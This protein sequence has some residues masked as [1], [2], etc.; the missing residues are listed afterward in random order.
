[1][2]MWAKAVE[3][4]VATGLAAGG[5][6]YAGMWPGSQ[7][8]GH[9]LTA[10]GLP[11]ELALTFDDGPNPRWTPNLLEVLARHEV[12][13]TFFLIGQYAAQQKALVREMQSAGH[14]LGNHTWTHPN[15]A[16]T[17]PGRTRE[18]LSRTKREIESITGAPVRLFRPPF[19]A[20]SPWTG[21]IARSLG[22]EV[23][24]WNAMTA[25]WNAT[26]PEPVAAALLKKIGQNRRAGHA[27]NLVLH[28]GSHRTPVAERGASVGAV[29]QILSARI[30]NV[31]LVTVAAWVG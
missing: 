16:R 20:R 4:S 13:A 22:M 23:V 11:G 14:T 17:G 31:R 10:P 15:L 7:I 6:A 21:P 2:E 5:Y 12:K 9:T 19:G 28:D 24:L 3:A 8:F 1:M 27:T 26:Q 30:A 29:E 25:D 18:E